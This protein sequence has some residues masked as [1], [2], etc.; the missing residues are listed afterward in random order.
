MK[1]TRRWDGCYRSGQPYEK[2]TKMRSILELREI[3]EQLRQQLYTAWE[4]MEEN[5]TVPEKQQ[6]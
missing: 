2:S 3:E 6:G 4:I 5:G 1:C